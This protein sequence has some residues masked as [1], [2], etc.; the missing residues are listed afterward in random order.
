VRIE[1]QIERPK[2]ALKVMPTPDI[3]PDT[4]DGREQAL[5]KHRLLQ[6][7]LQKL[8]LIIGTGAR[9]TGRVEIC[10][11]D[12]FAGPWGDATSD[13]Q[14]T[15]IA[16]SMQ[17]LAQCKLKLASL[18]V[19]ATMRALFVEKDVRAFDRLDTYLRNSAPKSVQASPRRGNFVELRQV[20]LDW[21]GRDAF[22][23][24]FIDPKGWKDIGIETL[25]PLLRRPRS[26][27]LINFMYGFINRAVSMAEQNSAIK[28]LLG[29]ALM[30][31][32]GLS[33]GVREDRILNTYR[34][35]LKGCVPHSRGEYPA[36]TA[37]VRVLD[38]DKERLKYHLVY[39]TSHP[40]GVIEFMAM[41]EHVDLVQ[42]QV[43]AVKRDTARTRDTGTQDMFGAQSHV[44][45]TEGRANVTDVDR[46]W[47][48]YLGS[49][50]RQVGK[51]EFADILET[52]D[53]FASDLQA[54]LARLVKARLVVNLDATESRPKKPLHFEKGERLQLV[55]NS[56]MHAA[57]EGTA[58]KAR[59]IENR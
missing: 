51:S 41:S 20:I 1:R 9:R 44:D 4:Y 15:S 47:I 33:P 26:E 17:T 10:Y 36:R 45:A 54:S 40:Q 34:K 39:L 8:V 29:E 21:C 3:I 49:G 38:P 43:R 6:S 58:G 53:W 16:V 50:V 11:V 22:T 56:P 5:V 35:N 55:A 19:D 28:A 42:R 30:L 57:N 27:F 37:Y 18:G 46:F 14:G 7:Y 12:C 31:E 32:A 2:V 59:L 52:T 48:D 25:R 13:L 24:F 23:F